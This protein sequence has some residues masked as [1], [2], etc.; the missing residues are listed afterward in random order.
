LVAKLATPIPTAARPAAKRRSPMTIRFQPDGRP[1]EEQLRD[2]ATLLMV[3]AELK[4]LTMN[5]RP[6]KH[7]FSGIVEIPKPLKTP[8]ARA[9]KKKG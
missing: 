7:R 3:V 1:A 2:P 9:T 4:T 8:T 5:W 6:G